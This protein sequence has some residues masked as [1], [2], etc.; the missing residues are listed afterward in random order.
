MS[1]VAHVKA[2]GVPSRSHVIPAGAM[3]LT[4]LCALRR[5][6]HVPTLTGAT[7]G[8]SYLT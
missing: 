3:H 8:I 5:Y 4:L 1:Q 2:V 7:A 6:R